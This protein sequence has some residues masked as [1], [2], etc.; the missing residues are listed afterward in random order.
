MNDEKYI[1]MNYDEL[2]FVHAYSVK[3]SPFQ[4]QSYLCA[5]Q[6]DPTNGTSVDAP[7]MAGPMVVY[8]GWTIYN[9]GHE[10]AKTGIS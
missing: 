9:I 6:K 10:A 3:E 2:W 7:K 5:V 8:G 4:K 1:R